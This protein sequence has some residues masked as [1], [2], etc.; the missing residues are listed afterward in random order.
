M[1][2]WT[3]GLLVAGFFS[4]LTFVL[5]TIVLRLLRIY[6]HGPRP[7]DTWL[8]LHSQQVAFI[9]AACAATVTLIV[10]ARATRSV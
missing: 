1:K 7:G 9:F 3:L 5:G 4:G 10:W 6:L 2:R 8:D